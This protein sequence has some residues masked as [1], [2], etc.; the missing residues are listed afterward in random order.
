MRHMLYLEKRETM[1]LHDAVETTLTLLQQKPKADDDT[2]RHDLIAAGIA[3]ELA[4]KLVC[5]VP[6]ALCRMVFGANGVQFAPNYITVDAAGNATG[7]ASFQNDAVYQ[8][9]YRCCSRVLAPGQQAEPYRLVAARSPDYRAIM[10]LH[11]KQGFALNALSLPPP[12]LPLPPQEGRQGGD[13]GA[14][15]SSCP[16]RPACR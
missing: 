11:L 16:H 7:T 9:V 1:S 5:F 2:L 10:D 12:H 6:I 15:L 8:E 3:P 14:E 4:I 13:S